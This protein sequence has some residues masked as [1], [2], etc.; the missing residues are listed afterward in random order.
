MNT[1]YTAKFLHALS[2]SAKEADANQHVVHSAYDAIVRG[3]FEAFGNLLADDV[4][5]DIRGSGSMDGV[6]RGR[7]NVVEAARRNF[8]Q[9]ADQ[10]PEIE[11]M[12]SQGDAIAV[13]FR[14]TGVFK[15]E[16]RDYRF[17]VVQWFTF[18]E[19]KIERIDEV[20]AAAANR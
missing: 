12:A 13:L 19:G 9:L 3:D 2:P 1:E 5:L 14:E 18:R 8:A 11:S 6:W 20:V 17:R 10:K 16:G 7:K 15:N 4:E